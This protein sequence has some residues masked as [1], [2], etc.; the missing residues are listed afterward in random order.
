VTALRRAAPGD[1]AALVE[2]EREVFG[3]H[4]Y[5]PA[6]LRQFVELFPDL[7]RVAV[8][9]D[10]SIAGYALGAVAFP[11][12]IGWI[13]SVAVVARHRGCGIG[14]ALTAALLAVFDEAGLPRVRLTVAPDNAPARRVYERLGF[15]VLADLPAYF[16]PGEPRV[17][18]ERGRPRRSP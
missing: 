8:A 15:A 10:G 7:A 9:A 6:A 4:A 11:E 1:L 17:L 5:D 18:M 12:R 14:A 16:G 13:L 3:T 2:V